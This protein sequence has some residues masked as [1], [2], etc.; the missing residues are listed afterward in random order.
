M[1]M[2]MTGFARRSVEQPW[3]SATWELKSVNHRYLEVNFRLPEAFR[4]YEAKWK[5]TLQKQLK[6]GKVE[7]VLKYMPGEQMAS[8]LKLNNPL[9]QQLAAASNSV[10][11]AF[12]K[13]SVINP[14]DVLAWPGV[15]QA[16]NANAEALVAELQL[17]LEQAVGQ[18]AE[19]R[20][21]EGKYL[22]DFMQQ[23]ISEMQALVDRVEMN[24]PGIL[25]QQQQKI[26]ERFKEL[27]VDCD[28]DRL[29][30]EMVW[31]MQKADVAEEL[32]RLSAHLKEV[33]AVLLQKGAVGRRL[34]FIMQELNRE[35]NTLASKSIDL[36]VTNASVDL[37]VLIEQMREQVQN[38]E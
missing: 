20:Q 7:C 25:E 5:S 32:H 13:E 36:G 23:R 21:T 4:L 10:H 18:L 9:I 29:E 34:D 8:E 37:K 19:M 3:G 33:Q 2:S 30:Q 35:A 31:L 17:E 11:A 16:E 22:Q 26:E 1:V 15:V 12:Q 24:M 38:I 28:K 6:R 14:V 27:E